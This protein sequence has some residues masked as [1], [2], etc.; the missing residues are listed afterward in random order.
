MFDF[1][2]SSRNIY[3][4]SYRT[5]AYVACLLAS[6][7]VFWLCTF[8]ALLPNVVGRPGGLFLLLLY[9]LC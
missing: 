9:M 5:R 6:G 1:M 2:F 7:L 4:S 3:F 8:D